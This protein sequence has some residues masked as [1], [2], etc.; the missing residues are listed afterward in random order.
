MLLCIQTIVY[1]FNKTIPARFG[2]KTPYE[3]WHGAKPTE[4]LVV[5][6]MC[7]STKKCVPSWMLRSP[8][9]CLLD[10]SIQAKVIDSGNPIH[11]RWEKLLML[12]LMK[13]SFIT[14][15]LQYLHTLL[16]YY[17]WEQN[18]LWHS[19]SNTTSYNRSSGN[20][21]PRIGPKQLPMIRTSQLHI[22]GA[23]AQ[24]H[25]LWNE[26]L[27]IVRKHRSYIMIK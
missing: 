19:W 21:P 20:K 23:A 2:D 8:S 14:I 5:L 11:K 16:N 26:M 22:V 12:F 4:F 24:L 7:S 25:V 17:K 27:L 18:K 13:H 9:L 6:C 10:T 1:L 3:I 15:S